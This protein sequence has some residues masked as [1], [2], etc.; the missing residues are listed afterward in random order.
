[1][2]SITKGPACVQTVCVVGEVL[3]VEVEHDVPSER[4]DPV[5]QPPEH[6][7]VRCTAEMGHEVESDAPDPVS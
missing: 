4:A 3:G 7:Q 5:H 1:M 6:V 2:W